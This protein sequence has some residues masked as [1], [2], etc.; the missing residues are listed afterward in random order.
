MGRKIQRYTRT[1][2]VT[3]NGLDENL[4]S[5]VDDI[6]PN[7]L[8]A[9]QNTAHLIRR[10]RDILKLQKEIAKFRDEVVDPTQRCLAELH[11]IFPSI[12]GSYKLMFRLHFDV[13]EYRVINV[14]IVDT[15]KLSD[16]LLQL[17]DSSYGVQRQGLKML[18]FANK[19]S[20][21]CVGY[22]EDALDDPVVKSG[23]CIESEI[24]LLQI[25]FRLLA[26]STQSKLSELRAEAQLEPQS[27]DDS[28][29]RASLD[30]VIDICRRLPTT[31]DG[32]LDTVHEFAKALGQEG[33]SDFR[34]VPNVKNDTVRKIEKSWGMH[35]VGFLT[36]CGESHLYSAKTFPEG[37]PD[38]GKSV[39]AMDDVY[40][41]SSKYLFEK[42][43]LAAMNAG[44]SKPTK[45]TANN[46]TTS[47]N[48]CET[49]ASQ[50][51][52]VQN[53]VITERSRAVTSE[54]RVLTAVPTIKPGNVNEFGVANL[55]V[56]DC[57][58]ATKN[59]SKE[60]AQ[61]AGHEQSQVDNKEGSIKDLTNEEK[62]LIA[63]R[64]IGKK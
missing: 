40:R 45:A 37:C 9:K 4:D 26:K 22:C 42:Q 41:Q 5:F 49:S 33:S 21:A 60:A 36:T 34:T 46:T 54:E 58:N 32:F 7:P 53:A 62:F 55:C 39:T 25:R 57:D 35:E 15:L 13:L 63:M 31:H 23:P 59:I 52:I 8:A 47:T 16:Y 29:L 12:I 50:E 28:R 3:K 19:E 2:E 27:A 61:K 1:I 14:R 30:A 43:F 56:D 24:R 20:T 51:I 64:G 11:D 44:D 48:A 38:C 10:Y 18:E 6:R 17:H